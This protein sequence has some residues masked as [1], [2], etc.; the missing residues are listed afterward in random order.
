MKVRSRDDWTNA[1][2]L[3]LIRG[4]DHAKE[5][6]VNLDDENLREAKFKEFKELRGKVKRSVIK[7]K[8]EYVQNK[9]NSAKK[10]GRL[11]WTELNELPYFQV[12]IKRASQNML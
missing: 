11:Y 1:S 3:N 5:T 4:R 2:L 10:D 6:F 7:A 8:R 9:L 12:K